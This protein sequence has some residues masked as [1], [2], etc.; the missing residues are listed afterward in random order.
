[1]VEAEQDV[2]DE[3]DALRDVGTLRR[4]RHGRL[5]RRHRVVA[6]VA[7]DRLAERLRLL[8]RD[9]PG[10]GAD[11]AVAAEPPPLDRLEQ[12]RPAGVL[13]QC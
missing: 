5:E 12:E 13:A 6:E 1:V 3:E 2:G 9:E 4:Q 11:E 7:D 8:E 10:S